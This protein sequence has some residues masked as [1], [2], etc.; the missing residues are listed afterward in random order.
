MPQ[1][2][3]YGGQAVL[4][5]VL[6]RGR[7]HSAIAVRRP[8]GDIALKVEP[9]GFWGA[10]PLRRYPF[11][12]G[13]VILGESLVQGMTA[14]QYS[15]NVSLEQDGEELGGRQMA[16]TITIALLVAA[17]IFFATPAII[18]GWTESWLHP[19]AVHV[20]EGLV[21]ISFLLAYLWFIGKMPDVRRLFAYHGAEH[22]TI[23]AFEAGVPLEVSEIQR[24]SP[25]HPRC[26]TSFLLTVMVVA[27]FVFAFLGQPP[28]VWRILSRVLL[29]PVVAGVS[30]EV[31]RFGATHL[32]NLFV[33]VFVEPGLALQRLTTRE[34]EDDQVEVALAAF[35]ALRE[36][37]A[38]ESVELRDAGSG[39]AEINA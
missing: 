38:K 29:L 24:F 27:V 10:S 12:R 17:V 23:H 15:A 19:F 14:L 36:V 21:R 28:P 7:T 32:G 11:T 37:E 22:K 20:L 6:M 16:F 18:A 30:Y 9:S 1:G 25:A 2:P 39:D 26:G 13:L 34:P 35:Q 3:S 5:G 31:L 4:E 33:H 8:S